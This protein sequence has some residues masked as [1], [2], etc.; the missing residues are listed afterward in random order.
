MEIPITELPNSLEFR[1]FLL[2][3]QLNVLIK[4]V[5]DVQLTEETSHSFYLCIL[6]KNLSLASLQNIN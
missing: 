3:D 2:M 5:K 6:K 1:S 4:K